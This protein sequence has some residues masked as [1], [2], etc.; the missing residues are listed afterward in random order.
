MSRGIRFHDTSYFRNQLIQINPVSGR[1][2]RSNC[3]AHVLDDIVGATPVCRYVHEDVAQRLAIVF[4]S[5]NKTLASMGAGDY[6]RQRLVK[7]MG[8]RCSHLTEQAHPAE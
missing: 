5:V 4:T 8:E 7:L 3:V 1:I 6:G 2:A